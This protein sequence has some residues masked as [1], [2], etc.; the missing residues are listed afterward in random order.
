[1][2]DDGK[3]SKCVGIIFQED[4]C[5]MIEHQELGESGDFAGAGINK[6]MSV[7]GNGAD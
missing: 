5:L 3:L 4:R 2:Y 1:V 6:Y 7:V